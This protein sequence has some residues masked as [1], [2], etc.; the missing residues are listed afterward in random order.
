MLALKGPCLHHLIEAQV[1]RTPGQAAV[2]FE[3]QGM[4]YRELDDRADRVARHLRGLGVGPEVLVALYLKRSLEMVVGI[5]GILKAGA[6][7]VPLDAGYPRERIAFMLGDA[8]VAC[9]LT[10]QDLVANLPIGAPPALCLDSFDWSAAAPPIQ[11]EAPCRPENL[12]Y[13]M[14][15]SGSTGRP[16]GACIEHRNIVSYVQGV[17]DRLRCE[18]GMNH[19]T[20]SSI[21]ADLGNTVIFPALATGG[22]LHVI[23]QDRAE[24][25]AMLAEYF[26]RERI[27][28]LKIVPSH[29]AALQTGRDPRDV[30]PRRRLILGGEAS[31]LDWIERLRALSPECEIHNHYGPTETTVGAMT[32]RVGALLPRTLSGTLP[33]GT[34]LPNSSA[35]ILDEGGKPVAVGE[36]GE[37][38]IG[39]RGVARGYLNRPDLT[40]EKFIPDPFSPNPGARLYRT[41]DLARTLRDGTFEFCGRID[42]QVKVHGYRIEL[43]EIEAA[44]R[45]H[46]GVAAAVVRLQ[47]DGSGGSQLAAYVVPRR[48]RQA[49]WGCQAVHVLPDGSPVAHLNRNETDYLY[50]EI[51]DRQ[52]YLRHGIALRDGDCV[53]DA[54][55][56][57]GLFTIFASRLARNLRIIS[58]EPNPSAFACLEVNAEAWGTAVTCL[59]V[60]VSS[61]NKTA[62]LTF[63]EG[64]SLLSGFY[65]DAAKERAVVKQ[66]VL[67]QQSVPAIREWLASELDD[68]IDE[69]LR[70]RSV[71]AVLRTLSSVIAEQGLEGIDLLKI[72]VEKSELD[73]LRGLEPRDWPRIRQ[74]VIEVDDRENL[75][76]IR[77]LLEQRGFEALVEQDPLLRD[78]ALCYVYAIR[79]SPGGARLIREPPPGAHVRALPPPDGQVLTPA[80]LR[81]HIKERLPQPMI[82]ASFVLMD[83]LPLTANGKVDRQAL[84]IP[85]RENARAFHG[86]A[87]PLTETEQTLVA[88]WRELLQVEN[89]APTDDFFDLGGHSLLAIK[90]V[91]RI[92]DVFGLELQTRTLFENPTIND[93]SRILTERKSEVLPF[94]RP[95]EAPGRPPRAV[96]PLQP[97][98]TRTP[99]FAVPGHNG[100]ILCYRVLA[101]NLGHDQPFFGLEPPGLDGRSAPLIR[102]EALATYFA[103]Q[104]G[105][106]RPHGPLIIA[107]F[108]AGGTVAFELGRRLLQA[109][110]TIQFIALLASP[111]P[112]WYRYSSQVPFYLRQRCERVSKHAR[113]LWSRPAGDRLRYA[114][115]RLDQVRARRAAASVAAL[116]PLLARRARVE[117]ATLA[118]VRRYTPRHFTGR[119]ALVA[120]SREWLPSA[121]RLWRSSA[122]R[123]TEYFGPRGCLGDTML[124]D[125]APQV[126]RLL[127]RCRE[128]HEEGSD[129]SDSLPSDRFLSMSLTR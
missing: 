85:S 101:L 9:T 38:Y 25:P 82:P 16:K 122:E 81:K 129:A 66:Y 36:K 58:L 19:A 68:L 54:G 125:Y 56:N 78:T 111:Y 41:G 30:M 61:E 84:P 40:C 127:R 116:D 23:S 106:F 35:C 39:G 70:A 2:M 90:A 27:D 124:G 24:N 22:C 64:M 107:G 74:M 109:G 37:L 123:T 105:A 46:P 14:Y 79:P 128:E 17:A 49:L 34:P 115:E 44:M 117:R 3:G 93:L 67:N 65:A 86:M 60:G 33:L 102:I 32:Y 45:E 13:V 100:D 98:G 103:D 8:S 118:A 48:A 55:A 12:A 119:I 92:R 11:P 91:S 51:F 87:R 26:R 114:T 95:A 20:V 43:G 47:E 112:T 89:I 77:A 80:T 57:I 97:R 71:P 121:A 31:R 126:A 83:K 28:V 7:Y 113:A 6:A 99:V 110:R 18:P 63:F 52:A 88:I 53:V 96:V 73:V 76:P 1:R 59:P 21:A 50:G 29:L 4:S 62:D 104:I 108:C 120:P 10:Q 5:L 69:R 15:T 72:N 94:V 42:D 75:G